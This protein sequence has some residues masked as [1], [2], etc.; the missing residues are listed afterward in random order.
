MALALSARETEQLIA[1][2]RALTHAYD[3]VE[4]RER[5]GQHLLDLFDAD[6]YASYIWNAETRQFE[7]RVS[8]NMDPAN[9]SRYETYYQHRD[10]ITPLLQQR[11]RATA[12]V[13]VLPQDELMRTEFFND[14]L[15]RDGL[16]YGMN[17]YA[18]DGHRNIGDMRIWRRRGKSNFDRRDLDLLDAIGPSFSNALKTFGRIQEST[19][20]FRALRQLPSAGEVMRRFDLTAREADIALLA[21]TG[22]SD[23]EIAEA[24]G[25]TPATVRTHMRHVFDKT[26]INSRTA[27]VARLFGH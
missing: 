10:P 13:E 25:I 24:A 20:E 27:L 21:G 8:I 2:M 1:V 17:F 6:F 12:V 18:Y 3:E 26:G 22:R 19:R 16:H 23:M 5:V 9:L 11:V 7:S 15:A 4:I 14:F